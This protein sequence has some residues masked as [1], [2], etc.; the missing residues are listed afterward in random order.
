MESL[1]TVWLAG[2]LALHFG[3]IGTA[4]ATRIAAGSRAEGLLQL[5][6]LLA[7]AGVALS[8]WYCHGHDLGLGIPSGL[9]LTAM[10]LTAVTDFRG[11]HEPAHL[12]PLSM[13]G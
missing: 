9:T 4:W 12:M 5:L 7:M 6:F 2:L 1:S 3:A 8:A 11:T 10:V 13:H